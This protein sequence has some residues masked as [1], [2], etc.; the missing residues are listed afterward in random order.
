MKKG[1]AGT[2]LKLA[3]VAIS[4]ALP[5]ESARFVCSGSPIRGFKAH[6]HQARLR[7]STSV[8]ARRRT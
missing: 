8:D 1:D 7:P 2:H 6:S 5:L 4:G 3:K